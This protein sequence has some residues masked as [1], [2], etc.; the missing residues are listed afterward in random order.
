MLRT[1]VFQFESTP[2]VPLPSPPANCLA[3]LSTHDLP[4]F[5]AYL[6]GD[7]IAAR[8]RL[9]A[10]TPDQ[11][12]DELAARA[13]WRG[14]LLRVLGTSSEGASEA[15]VTA[16]ALR[17]CLAHL[18]RSD[19]A[20][21]LVDLEELWDER[22]PQNVPGTGPEAGNWRRRSARTIEEISHDPSVGD[23]LATVERERAS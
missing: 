10:L 18:A 12:A 13:E 11:S 15:A 2:E 6:W 20:I 7:D 14:R 17:G 16:A 21:V 23:V 5:G 1:W 19:A 4:R 9:G 8:E 3:T 22:Q